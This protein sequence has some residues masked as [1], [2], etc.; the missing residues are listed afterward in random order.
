MKRITKITAAAGAFAVA[1]AVSMAASTYFKQ[2][3]E[4]AS[5]YT[6]KYKLLASTTDGST[7]INLDNVSHK[8]KYDANSI[9][10]Y[11]GEV[12]LTADLRLDN[13][14]QTI[15]DSNTDMFAVEPAST[16]GIWAL[17]DADVA[18]GASSPV[19]WY[20]S[21]ARDW[22][23]TSIKYATQP[24][25][26]YSYVSYPDSFTT[27]DPA[28][29]PAR[30]SLPKG[31]KQSALQYMNISSQLDFE[32]QGYDD[33]SSWSMTPSVDSYGYPTIFLES[34]NN[35]Y[36]IEIK[37]GSYRNKG[38]GY[39]ALSSP[40][41]T[42]THYGY[43]W[44]GNL[45]TSGIKYSKTVQDAYCG[46]DAD[47]YALNSR[48]NSFMC[49][50]VRLLMHE[51]SYAAT[52]PE[53]TYI[54][55]YGQDYGG[56]NK[57]VT[58]VS[59][60]RAV[61][62]APTVTM[63]NIPNQHYDVAG[64]NVT[65]SGTA[66]DADGDALSV[67][68]YLNNTSGTKLATVTPNSASAWSATI[69]TKGM[70]LGTSQT[71]VAVVTDGKA[72]AE[73]RKAFSITNTSPT[74]TINPISNVSYS[75]DMGNISVSGNWT[76][77]DTNP[78]DTISGYI[79]VNGSKVG[80]IT[81]A[82]GGT[83]SATIP[84][85]Y[86]N[87]IKQHSVQVC[88]TDGIITSP[89]TATTTFNVTNSTP[90]I[91]PAK[92]TDNSVYG[93]DYVFTA[94]IN[95]ANKGQ[96]LTYSYSVN[97][98]AYKILGTKTATG[99]SISLTDL[100][101]P[102]AE[103]LV[104]SNTITL[105]VSDGIAENTATIS[106]SNKEVT[107]SVSVSDLPDQQFTT[108]SNVVTFI[109]EV[110]SN[111]KSNLTANATFDG[112]TVPGSQISFISGDGGNGTYKINIDLA[113]K[114]VKEGYALSVT[115]NSD[116]ASAVSDTAKVNVINTAPVIK[117]TVSS[118]KVI[119]AS[120]KLMSIPVSV[121]DINIGQNMSV[122]YSVDGG[123]WTTTSVNYV[124]TGTKNAEISVP[125]TRDMAGQA[126]KLRV[127]VYDSID[128]GY[129]NG[130][131]GS[132]GYSIYIR[133]DASLIVR[134]ADDQQFT[135]ETNIV[136][137]E[138]EADGDDLT[139]TAVFNGKNVPEANISSIKADGSFTIKVDTANLP[140]SETSYELEVTVTDGSS[141]PV[142]NVGTVRIINTAPVIKATIPSDKTVYISEGKI[143]VPVDI[144]DLNVG[145]N[146]TVSYSIDGK[147]WIDANTF[148]NNG[149]KSLT[150]DIP[151]TSAMAG[152][153]IHIRFRA[154]DGIDYGYDNGS[155]G[156]GYAIDVKS[157]VSLTV[158]NAEDQQYTVESNLVMFEC[159]ATGNDLTVTAE[160]NG[161]PVP[162]ANISAVADNGKF[163][164][165]VDTAGLNIGSHTLKVTV[166]DGTSSPVTKSGQV[167]IVN[168]APLIKATVDTDNPVYVIDGSFTVPVSI[169]DIN[170][171]QNISVQYS[172][173]GGKTWIDTGLDYTNNGSK[174]LDVVVPLT[175]DMINTTF[176]LEF[177]AFDGTD[178]GYDI[179]IG[180]GYSVIVL[181]EYDSLFTSI[182]SVP[183]Q[184][185]TSET[186][187]VT[188]NCHSSDPDI[189]LTSIVFNG[190]E[191]PA[192]NISAIDGNGNFTVKVD[193]AN[194]SIS[195]DPYIL[196]VDAAN[197]YESIG[198][199]TGKV[200]I[201]NAAPSVVAEVVNKK[202]IYD[203]GDTVEVLVNVTDANI[204]QTISLDY[205]INGG[206]WLPASDS[207]TNTSDGKTVKLDIPSSFL[208]ATGKPV[209]IVFKASDGYDSTLSAAVAVTL[210]EAEVPKVNNPPVISV[211]DIP[212]RTEEGKT[213]LVKVDVTEKDPGDVIRVYR[214]IDGNSP[215]L[216][217][218]YISDGNKHPIEDKLPDGLKPGQHTVVYTCVD[219]GGLTS[220]DTETFEIT[221]AY[222]E[223]D[224]TNNPPIISITD[225]PDDIEENTSIP[226]VVTVTEKDP[227][228]VVKVYR[229]IDG[230]D[231]VLIDT[232]VSDGTKRPIDDKIP[233]LT[234]GNHT[235]KYIC[236]DQ[237]GLT[238]ED[239]KSIVITETKTPETPNNPPTLYID[240]ITE[241]TTADKPIEITLKVN[242]EDIGQRI[243]VYYVV[244]DEKPVL[245]KK[246]TSKGKIVTIDIDIKDLEMGNHEIIF[247]A[248]DEK[249]AY[250]NDD[251]N[252]KV[253]DYDDPSKNK[254]NVAEVRVS[255]TP[256]ELEVISKPDVVSE[257][258]DVVIGIET[259]DIDI[260]Q[261]VAVYYVLDGR[262]PVKIT[263][264]ISNGT[265]V[266]SQ[267]VLDNL[268]PGRHVIDIY[269]IDEL[270]ARSDDSGSFNNRNKSRV[271]V[272]VKAKED[273]FVNHPPVLTPDKNNQN[274]FTIGDDAK[275]RFSVND[276]DVG[277]K[278]TVYYQIDNGDI[279][280][281]DMFISN[282][283]SKWLDI[284][285]SKLPVGDH[286][287]RIW[288][289]DE[290]GDI[291]DMDNAIVLK[292]TI[293]EKI[294]D[295]VKTGVES[296][297][298]AGNP[299]AMILGLCASIAAVISI[300]KKFK[301]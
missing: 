218:T 268:A 31:G 63:S 153:V 228:D 48:K 29:Y 172:L 283:V 184:Q 76:D 113:G 275:I 238:S 266:P 162:A 47:L 299:A 100:V 208:P 128:Y 178:Y 254:P 68:L 240:S 8:R 72:S 102:A 90:S 196:Q 14:A 261:Q 212:D 158:G 123:A 70:G 12:M 97:G 297:P 20:A 227:G 35:D 239:V 114:P 224:H 273:L 177:R 85:S 173:D 120:D 291:S 219:Q 210:K 78:K 257:G 142:S 251:G 204:G 11:G 143:S 34:P 256:P 233:G 37:T 129:D 82:S 201:V 170:I 2:P 152:Q 200:K 39:C 49:T 206:L 199:G 244:D 32:V 10:F 52:S 164:V 237:D 235:I 127:R 66:S 276:E 21:E 295:P 296:G 27:H 241:T 140:V 59:V 249:D 99:S 169:E 33:L 122:E 56:S 259:I 193:T 223:P 95:D 255:N 188:F 6:M 198:S 74:V 171:G 274:D 192:E 225:I 250:S 108:E 106:L 7:K 160:F 202:D 19:V 220:E 55:F 155:Q 9:G 60:Y 94:S 117:A 247:Y 111:E 209:E 115:V 36:K 4:A 166:T 83:W 121:S 271:E 182:D 278:V 252:V 131:S 103:L 279:I 211:S 51:L 45:S 64:H 234:P 105:K 62:N 246:F 92:S 134:S 89:V 149:S 5:S 3:I 230:G 280:K 185:Y 194:L 226:V 176:V 187:I 22:Y 109:V 248:V 168:T 231:P 38:A 126:I 65:V 161:T 13:Y 24:L 69:N 40:D 157:D 75:S 61:N 110:T 15:T 136:T 30:S 124:N 281:L 229:V 107:M 287:I 258:E 16:G 289:V 203:E 144:T 165:T 28:K 43:N 141:A 46:T 163:T 150:I 260:S 216:I 88:L 80:N 151:V 116:L 286:T 243:W 133:K 253:K 147:A 262:W 156:D 139:A 81:V 58:E 277:Q 292:I 71:I 96:T 146:M 293:K 294:L 222:K 119:Y 137:F 183:N 154:Y 190:V 77:A 236:V 215:I 221:E 232:F 284:D 167:K 1:A 73:A 267:I 130:D 138:C 290:A 125:I 288:A 207:W 118:D 245:I 175:K 180:N 25:T 300:K 135:T 285:L 79:N 195:S 148:T 298:A 213:I 44:N 91:V 84:A 132:D 159:T 270:G 269:A 53:T 18:Y 23:V 263:D 112:A 214:S 301:N 272:D 86:V 186:N 87:I 282:G 50:N 191:V 197:D 189:V 54:G 101:I 242:D 205:S 264:Y 26:S 174:Q 67:S 98:G 57:I 104:D 145:Q 265:K 179:G 41:K 93:K 181:G 217:D 17:S 42:D